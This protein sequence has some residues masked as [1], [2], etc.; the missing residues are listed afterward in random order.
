MTVL[1][2]ENNSFQASFSTHDSINYLTSKTQVK[3]HFLE[4]KRI[5]KPNGIYLF[6]VS[7][8]HN[9]ITNFHD[10]RIKRNVEGCTIEWNNHYDFT[11]NE[12]LSTLLFKK[13]NNK[14]QNIINSIK[15][16]LSNNILRR[17]SIIQEFN[18]PR[19]EIHKQQIYSSQEMIDLINEC[20]LTLLDSYSDYK[21]DSNKQN[22]QL[23]IYVVQK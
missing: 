16:S 11:S 13:D 15:K 5:L 2:F 21:K 8:E 7:T 22:A 17:D 18:L 4:I 20:G 3:Q 10:R 23:Q 1:P 9:I 12:L 14:I 19:L 6:D